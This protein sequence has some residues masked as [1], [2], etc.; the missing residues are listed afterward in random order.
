[1][2]PSDLSCARRAIRTR[3]LRMSY[4]LS[5]KIFMRLWVLALLGICTATRGQT[6]PQNPLDQQIQQ[7]R[8]KQSQQQIEQSQQAD[9]VTVPTGNP[10]QTAWRDM[11]LPAESHCF[12]LKDL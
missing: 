12:L 8:A 2:R 7:D 4:A 9:R 6:T 3:A 1:M 11:T 5:T 10:S